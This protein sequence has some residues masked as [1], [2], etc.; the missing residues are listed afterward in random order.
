MNRRRLDRKLHATLCAL[1]K[2]ARE[3]R[4]LVMGSVPTVDGIY[5][6]VRDAERLR[7]LHLI[8][9]CLAQITLTARGIRVHEDGGIL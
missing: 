8:T 2:G 1:V 4:A 9:T 5:V 6:S 3:N 7:E